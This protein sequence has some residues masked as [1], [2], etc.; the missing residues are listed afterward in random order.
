MI[1]RIV[2]SLLPLLVVA[3]LMGQTLVGVRAGWNR[4][5][6]TG[7]PRH[8]DAR[9]GLILGVD[10]ALP[11]ANAIELRVGGAYAQKGYSVGEKGAGFFSRG[12]DY[13]QL[14]ALARVG[15]SRNGRLSVG[16][17]TGPWTAFRVSCNE[18]SDPDL[19]ESGLI[20]ESGCGDVKT[21]D[22]GD[23]GRRRRGHGTRTLGGVSRSSRRKTSPSL[24]TMRA[25]RRSSMFSSGLPSTMRMSAKPPEAAS[26][27]GGGGHC[28]KCSRCPSPSTPLP[29]RSGR[30]STGA[31]S[32]SAA[33]AWS[34][35]CPRSRCCSQPPSPEVMTHPALRTRRREASALTD[36]SM[37]MRRSRE[38]ERTNGNE[39]S[40]Y[41]SACAAAV[42]S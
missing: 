8:Q 21:M 13:F 40:A 15:T 16:A 23:R 31:G 10:A 39:Y 36:S 37:E 24:I 11:L 6:N 20:V 30:L 26:T 7:G 35:G 17:L 19:L 22:F 42:A 2:V 12:L 14:S 34:G 32:R 28:R 38:R 4:S 29:P 41:S 25:R 1:R 18:S 5:T 9:K 33:T 3:P 27:G